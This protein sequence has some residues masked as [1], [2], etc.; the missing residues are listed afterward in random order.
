MIIDLIMSQP[1][2]VPA[3]AV[4]LQGLTLTN[5]WLKASAGDIEKILE[6][7]SEDIEELWEDIKSSDDNS[8]FKY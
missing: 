6:L 2:V 1:R 5:S 8:T 4:R 3:V 7:F